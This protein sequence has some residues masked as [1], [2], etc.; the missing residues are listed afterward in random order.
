MTQPPPAL[1]LEEL[2]MLP[3]VLIWLI[4]VAALTVGH[5]VGVQLR[6]RIGPEAE[7]DFSPK[8]VSG[9]YLGASLGLL[10]LLVGF[11]FSMAIDRYTT[12][13]GLVSVEA[14]ALSTAYR[15]LE[16]L[17]EPDRTRL[18]R[19]L[20][21]YVEA[22]EAFSRAVTPDELRAAEARTD[23]LQARFWAEIV[24]SAGPETLT[25][26][27]VFEATDAM[28]NAAAARRAALESSIPRAILAALLLYAV[29]AAGLMGY[30][31]PVTRRYVLPS[32]IQFFLLSLALG[33][34]VDLDRPRTGLVEVSQAPM[35]RAATAIRAA[36][37]P[38]GPLHR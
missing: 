2:S 7:R 3:I 11:S 34:I 28:F 20:L 1:M 30:S 10:A 6:R 16:T 25:G 27:A 15:Q 12:Q 36:A 21:P 14:N 13:R 19:A 32:T 4:V 29:I 24:G 23:Q 9:N 5:E 17:G 37:P 33:L 18:S 31:H 22:R 8:R 35:F 38:A 26:R